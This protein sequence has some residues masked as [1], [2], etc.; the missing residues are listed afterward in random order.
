[1]LNTQD[2][3][4]PPTVEEMYDGAMHASNLRVQADRNGQADV[5]IAMGWSPSRVGAALMRLQSE[6][7]G[8]AHQ[9]KPT[10][11]AVDAI[12][13]SLPRLEDGKRKEKETVMQDG[14]PVIVEKMVPNLVLD[15]AVAQ[16][17]A[18]EWHMHEIK[19]L[20]GK[21]KTLPDVRAQLATWARLQLINNADHR[22]AEILIWHLDHI[23]PACEG[24]CKELI[25]N[26][27]HKSHKDC[28]VCRGTGETRIP[29][30]QGNDQY[31][32]ESKKLLRYIN[33]CVKT[34]RTALKQRLRPGKKKD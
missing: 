31:L 11:A 24:R 3:D 19:I 15:M 6:W 13:L 26:T 28:K 5:I 23:C 21:L 25:Q 17:M 10:R 32:H 34:A 8:A 33:D 20:L 27:P 2:E 9:K 4:L 14:K 22:V 1:M 30:Q 16:R 18:H 12:A 29:H 7:S